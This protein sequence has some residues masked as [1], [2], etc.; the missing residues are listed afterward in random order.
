MSRY[1]DMVKKKK[2]GAFD[3][4]KETPTTSSVVANTTYQER[5]TSRFDSMV[6]KKQAGQFGE[7]SAPKAAVVESP[8]EKGVYAHP[9]NGSRVTKQQLEDELAFNNKQRQQMA[10]QS[11]MLTG[12]AYYSYQQQA[13]KKAQEAAQLQAALASIT[14]QERAENA[15]K[16]E[17]EYTSR[18]ESPN[19]KYFVEQGKGSKDNVVE[20][21]RANWEKIAYDEAHGIQGNKRSIYR[22]MTDDQVQTYNYI[23]GKDGKDAADAYLLNIEEALQQ[24][25]GEAQAK[26]IEGIGGIGEKVAKGVYGMAAGSSN[27]LEG[28]RQNRHEDALATGAMQ[29][30]SQQLRENMGKI[31]GTLYDLS[32]QVGNMLPSMVASAAFGGSGLLAKG[33]ASAYTG[34]SAKGNAYN[35]AIKDGYSKEQ[36]NTYSTLI[37]ASEGILQY[38]L[39]GIGKLGGVSDEI[40]L[41]KVKGIDNAFARLALTGLIKAGSEVAEEEINLLL[42]PTLRSL[43]LNEEFS[44]PTWNDVAYTALLSALSVGAME[45]VPNAAAK[46]IN[47][48]TKTA[49]DLKNKRGAKPLPA[50]TENAPQA[51]TGSPETNP[52]Q[53]AENAPQAMPEAPSAEAAKPVL[54]DP[55]VEKVMGGKRVESS[56]LSS[57]AFNALA[58]R[59]DVAIDAKDNAY[60]MAPE[61][62]IDQRDY[63]SVGKRNVNAF[64]FDHPELHS[65]MAAAAQDLLNDA[66]Y[67]L[68]KGKTIETVR[69]VNGKKRYQRIAE[70]R[71]LRKAMEE[72]G[73]SRNQI[74]KAA[75][76]LVANHGQENY[77]A[78]KRLELILDEMLTKGYT[79]LDGKDVDPNEAYINLKRTLVGST[80]PAKGSF[81]AYVEEN[82]L[83]LDLGEVTMEQLRE[84]YDSK[85]TPQFTDD[86]VGAANAGFA[87][88]AYNRLYDQSTEFHDEGANLDPSKYVEVPKKDFDGRN[89]PKSS[90][91]IMGAKA[92]PD[93]AVVRLQELVASGRLSFDTI[94]DRDVV[95]EAKNKIKQKH[96]WGAVQ[97][98]RDAV[99]S[100]VAT[101]QNVALGQQ[102]IIEAM[103]GHNEAALA[104]LLTLYTRNSTNIAQALQA[105][106]MFRKLSPQG[107]LVAIEKAVQAFNEKYGTEAKIDKTDMGDFIKAES[108]EARNEVAERIMEN[109]AKGVPK[110]FRA[111]FDAIR[112]FAMLGNVRTHVRNMFGNAVFAAPVTIKNRVGAVGEILLNK[113]TGG[114]T[115]RTKSLVGVAPTS[116]LAKAARAD[117]DVYAKD[118]L[119]SFGGQYSEG[120]ASLSAIEQKMKTFGEEGKLGKVGKAANTLIDGN[121]NLLEAEDMVA[122]K[123]HYSQAL[124]G[125]LQANGVT[126]E[127]FAAMQQEVESGKKP[128]PKE[129]QPIIP[130][131]ERVKAADRD[132]YGNI[133]SYNAET[134]KYRVHFENDKGHSADVDLDAEL[135]SP[136]KPIK[137]QK[138]ES[139]AADKENNPAAFIDRARAYAARE[140]LRNTFTDKN[141]FSDAVASISKLQKSDNGFLRLMSTVTEGLL[142]FK[143]TPANILAR[144]VEYSPV[145]VIMGAVDTVRGATNKNA[146]Q[147]T[148][149]LDTVSA[150]AVGSAMLYVGWLL[151]SNGV[152]RGAEDEDEDQAGFDDL[153]GHQAYALE[154]ADG[155][156][157]TLDWLAPMSIPMFMGVELYK[158][159]QTKGLSLEEVLDS[160]KNISEPMLEMSMLQGLADVFESGAYAQN[161]GG[162]VIGSVVS[163]A[164]TNYFTQIFPTL[165]GQIERVFEDERMTTY[166]DKNS[167]LP[168]GWQY[169]I[170][171]VANKT[172]F[173]DYNQI[174]YI[175]AWGQTESTGNVF[176]RAVNNLI[177]PAYTSKVDRDAVEAELQRV[178]D[179]TGDGGVF[180][181]KAEKSIEFTVKT[182]DAATGKEKSEKV[183]IDL[184]AEQYV[185]YAKLKGQKSYEYAKAAIASAAYKSMSPEDR[186]KFINEMYDFANFEAAKSVDSRYGKTNSTMSKYAE[187]KAQGISPAQWFAIR[188]GFDDVKGEP[189]DEWGNTK[190]GTKKEA[191]MEYI[192]GL[193]LTPVQKDWL[194]I[195]KH[196]ST[197]KNPNKAKEADAKTLAAAPWN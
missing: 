87:D 53:I 40:L 106:A 168:T 17:A 159:M 191:N 30:G 178:F 181:T 147:I 59:G 142:P 79:T 62:H 185:K 88:S 172:P 35:Q 23:L 43:I 189:A 27:A 45:G 46:G 149:G 129:N 186:A 101:K 132:N 160:F 140:A 28:M 154:L 67:S 5:G 194:L 113:A 127:Q 50:A 78:A 31:G 102:L 83:P 120:K 60:L 166:A 125:Y 97:E 157:I 197:N 139:V 94:T 34:F 89:I 39:S 63:E 171:K 115:E 162:S 85:Q 195:W 116:A 1:N 179:N 10:E 138:L 36:A 90:S 175:D 144:A 126:A 21:S 95:T 188:E 20:E 141:A 173:V 84:E 19:A 26:H 69:T 58:E 110:D 73:L 128:K 148:Q 176:E 108:E 68:D 104:E 123:F 130:N 131:G 15:G 42:E 32:Y 151:A 86:G 137:K 55:L 146:E 29:F 167:A 135:I 98:Y 187:A 33:V 70:T 74:M 48:L 9:I 92:T 93:R 107:Q 192:D 196:G 25:E 76:D 177:N 117:F 7:L 64:Q 80:T 99:N 112:Y 170:G 150:G 193:N 75:Q 37:G 174:P 121:S 14:R 81:E 66:A 8:Y 136:L 119:S 111:K 82:R 184:T 11:A 44:A 24:K 100:N 165:F 169:T 164:A 3:P 49:Q 182:K 114:K 118:F 180:P 158:A 22:H 122:K 57:E 52:A 190:S 51:T 143:R 18:K 38:L 77:A 105:Q 156:S 41:A 109:I 145:G 124:A 16:Q 56:Q 163:T 47:L 6:A 133:I 72:V 61:Q 65:H 2:S 91:T 4:N 152:L 183:K 134:N 153:L 161:S 155:T 13:Q 54:N 103:N 12:D 71:A 96:F